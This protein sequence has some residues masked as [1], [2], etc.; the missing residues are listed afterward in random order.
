MELLLKKYKSQKSN[1]ILFIES[2]IEYGKGN[3]EKSCELLSSLVK[4]D[5]KIEYLKTLKGLYL[6]LDKTN[7]LQK[8]LKKL[9][10]EEPENGWHHFELAKTFNNEFDFNYF[11][12][13]INAAIDLAPDETA[14]IEYKL[15]FIL[16]HDHALEES[17]IQLDSSEIVSE[18]EQLHKKNP[19][20]ENIQILLI[21]SFYKFKYFDR[22]RKIRLLGLNIRCPETNFRMGK[23]FFKVQ[24]IEKATYHFGISCKSIY[25]KYFSFYYLSEC[26]KMEYCKTKFLQFLKLSYESYHEH[27]RYLDKRSKRLFESSNF[28]EQKRFLKEKATAQKIMSKICLELHL[29]E[30]GDQDTSHYLEKSL[31]IFPENHKAL[32]LMGKLHFE[33]CVNESLTYSLRSLASD[34]SFEDGHRLAA[35]CYKELGNYTKA[36]SHE[37]I[38]KNL[39]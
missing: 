39:S 20:S 37:E 29:A 19:N 22:I 32:H 24:D 7:D 6:L 11:F 27:I 30:Y 34:W 21:Q 18:V 4:K 38:A 31:N 17:G 35:L 9:I 10:N 15:K 2:Q 12:Y 16:R 8:I 13:H 23:A 14:F 1:E 33:K 25:Y 28:L 36:A 26:Y 3:T 5:P